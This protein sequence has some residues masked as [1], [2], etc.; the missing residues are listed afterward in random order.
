M[1]RAND[2]Q[3][4]YDD[5]GGVSDDSGHN[6]ALQHAERA[7]ILTRRNVGGWEKGDSA[8][9]EGGAFSWVQMAQTFFRSPRDELVV[10]EIFFRPFDIQG[11]EFPDMDC[12]TAMLLFQSDLDAAYFLELPALARDQDVDGVDAQIGIYASPVSANEYLDYTA[13]SDG[14]P[15]PAYF[16]MGYYQQEHEA[17]IADSLRTGFE[18]FLSKFYPGQSLFDRVAAIAQSVDMGVIQCV[19]T[20][21]HGKVN[22]QLQF[23]NETPKKIYIALGRNAECAKELAAYTCI[24]HGPLHLRRGVVSTRV[25][26]DALKKK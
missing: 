23:P 12:P 10:P 21:I 8:A 9:P 15:E 24:V 19:L 7:I 14:Y 4:F 2:E 18:G 22:A 25:M 13:A 3:D 6:D 1:R 26:L 11:A 20:N 17:F 16:Y 5:R